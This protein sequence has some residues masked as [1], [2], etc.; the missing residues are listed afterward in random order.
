MYGQRRLTR[1]EM[2]IYGVVIATL[3][4]VFADY[5]VDYME[6]AEKTAMQ[7]TVTNVTAALN[8]R[9]A[10]AVMTGKAINPKRWLAGNPFELAKAF[11]PNY[12]GEVSAGA[13]EPATRPAWF[14]DTAHKEV[15]YLPRLHSH[16]EVEDGSAEI[17]FRLRAHPSGFGF[18]LVPAPSYS[19]T[20]EA[21]E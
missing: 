21:D 13:S 2:A 18:V 5:A 7:T 3:V 6:M 14:F 9:Y 15:V 4:V 11:P 19:W 8:I 17:R 1:V 16:L 20:L 12:T 10:A